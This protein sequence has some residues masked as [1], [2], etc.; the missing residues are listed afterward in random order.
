MTVLE[1]PSLLPK[2]DGL[3]AAL[4]GDLAH[5]GALA[6][7]DQ[8]VQSGA[9]FLAGLLLASGSRRRSSA[10]PAMRACPRS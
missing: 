3:W 2:A 10:P 5:K 8:A 9:S 6:L 7:G 4:T 1:K